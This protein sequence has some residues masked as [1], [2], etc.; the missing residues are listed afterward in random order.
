MRV[1]CP[2]T[3]CV[4]LIDDPTDYDTRD[5]VRVLR[6]LAYWLLRATI[7]QIWDDCLSKHAR[8][9][10]RRSGRRVPETLRGG[11][12]WD[13]PNSRPKSVPASYYR[14]FKLAAI[15][16]LL[17]T[18]VRN[19]VLMKYTGILIKKYSNF[20]DVHDLRRRGGKYYFGRKTKPYAKKLILNRGRNDAYFRKNDGNTRV[21][22]NKNARRRFEKTKYI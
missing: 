19:V 4:W 6:E 5:A 10:R 8:H 12:F 9:S 20:V 15:W 22:C 14:R 1:I 7:G 11:R 17:R 16:T 2:Y 18:G 3:L 21:N 13:V